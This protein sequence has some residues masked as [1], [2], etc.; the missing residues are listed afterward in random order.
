MFNG[1]RAPAAVGRDEESRA[2]GLLSHHFTTGDRPAL[3]QAIALYQQLL[4]SAAPDTG[5]AVARPAANLMVALQ[6]RYT[7]L[8]RP[9]DLDAL[10]DLAR[11]RAECEPVRPQDVRLLGLAYQQRFELYRRSEDLDRAVDAFDRASRLPQE[12]ETAA[13]SLGG[14]A[15]TLQTRQR[16][17]VDRGTAPEGGQATQPAPP[18]SAAPTTPG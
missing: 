8:G 14:L 15:Q 12:A 13:Q 1:D 17:A 7:L 9:D 2:D 4:S 10:V 6:T 5:R 16:I 11:E 18:D 3:D